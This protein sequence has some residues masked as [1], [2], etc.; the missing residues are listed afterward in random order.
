MSTTTTMMN[1]NNTFSI[2]LTLFI[3]L[4]TMIPSNNSH[5]TLL[6]TSIHELLKRQGLP[7]GLFPINVKAF[8]LNSNGLLEVYFAEPCEAKFET[9]VRFETVVRANLTYGEL[10]DVQGLSQEEL[11]LWLPVKDIVV[12]DPS[13]GIIMFNIGVAKKQLAFSI[14]EDPPICKPPIILRM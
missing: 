10:N 1:I 7:G 14:F 13:S 5:N 2:I 4:L 11:F 3:I 6:T 9:L 12:Q 8:T